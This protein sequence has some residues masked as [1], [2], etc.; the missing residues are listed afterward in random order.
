MLCGFPAKGDALCSNNSLGEELSKRGQPRRLLSWV[1]GRFR[2]AILEVG[3][4]RRFSLSSATL[5]TPGSR[6]TGGGEKNERG[7]L[8]GKSENL[9]AYLLGLT[10]G[11]G[12]LEP[13][14]SPVSGAEVTADCAMTQKSAGR[15]VNGIVAHRSP[16][17][18]AI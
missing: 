10:V 14:T 8:H 17:L 2:L 1:R 9:A 11:L 3:R 12:G 13:P 6:A 7:I 16:V 4:G 18:V 5:L 15:T